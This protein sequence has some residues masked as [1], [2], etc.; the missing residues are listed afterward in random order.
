MT[1]WTHEDIVRRL[2]NVEHTMQDLRE[3]NTALMQE[4]GVL[5]QRLVDAIGEESPDGK[6]GTGL[7]G[8][9]ARLQNKVDEIVALKN[10]GIGIVMAVS[11]FGALIVLGI[12]GWIAS[13]I[14]THV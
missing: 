4:R 6:G 10:T 11:L 8:R 1:V 5:L 9:I 3:A 2:E 7:M 13:V 14:G 12:R